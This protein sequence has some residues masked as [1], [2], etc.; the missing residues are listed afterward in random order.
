MALNSCLQLRGIGDDSSAAAYLVSA[1]VDGPPG[2]LFARQ[3]LYHLSCTPNPLTVSLISLGPAFH[4]H[5]DIR[6]LSAAGVTC[7]WVSLILLPV[8]MYCT[9][10]PSVQAWLL[11]LIIQQ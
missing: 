11:L 10:S 6:T 7:P 8:L 9:H 5:K 2:F 1:R 4:K 3:A